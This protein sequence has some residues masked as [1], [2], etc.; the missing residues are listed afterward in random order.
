MSPNTKFTGLPKQFWANVRIISQHVGYTQ[1]V[2]RPRPY[3]DARKT[4]VKRKVGPI[5]VPNLAEITAALEDAEVRYDH[6]MA[7]AGKPTSL[8][9]QVL[10]YFDYRADVLN[11]YVRTKLMDADDAKFLFNKLKAKLHPN[12]PLPM[13]KQKRAK[14][15]PAYFTGAINMLIEANANGLP[16]NYNPLELTTVTRNGAPFELWQGESTEPFQARLIQLLFGK[17]RNTITRRLSAVVS[18]TAYMN[19]FWMA[20]NSKS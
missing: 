8:G 1:R 16:C 17:S 15:A 20:W 19:P 12:C 10:E 5:K 18:L 11:N 9:V 14:K 2:A 6:L 3:K 13:N 4:A 7:S